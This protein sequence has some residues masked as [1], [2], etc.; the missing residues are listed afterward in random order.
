MSN[1]RGSLANGNGHSFKDRPFFDG[2][3]SPLSITY[4]L[5]QK[6]LKK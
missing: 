6:G 5:G 4:I 1:N 3:P 2:W